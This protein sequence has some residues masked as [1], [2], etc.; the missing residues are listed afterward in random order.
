M[1]PDT[2]YKDDPTATYRGYRR[3]ALYCLFRLFDV[4]LPQDCI[5]QPEGHEDVAIYDQNGE[6]IE[7]VQVKDYSSNLTVSTFKPSFY[8]RIGGFCSADSTV[9][10]KIASFGPVGP[11]LARALHNA[12]ETPQR[13]LDT[14][15]KDR[16]IIDADG[17]RTTVPGV[18]LE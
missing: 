2:R 10:V 1:I 7:I 18:S 12:Q 6:L 14:L 8:K 4:G 11:E 5:V 15:T 9:V 3:Q 13:A 16:E 17:S